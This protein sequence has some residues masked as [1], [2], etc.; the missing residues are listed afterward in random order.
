RQ[1]ARCWMSRLALSL[2]RNKHMRP[3]ELPVWRSNIKA[4]SH[5]CLALNDKRRLSGSRIS[6]NGLSNVCKSISKLAMVLCFNRVRVTINYWLMPVSVTSKH[7]AQIKS[8][9]SS[10]S[11]RKKRDYRVIKRT[12]HSDRERFDCRA[13]YRSMSPD[14][15]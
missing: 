15:G 8:A 10:A 1:S 12:R 14:L 11:R 5:I 6:K 3:K 7:S 2:N 4:H 9:M 13:V